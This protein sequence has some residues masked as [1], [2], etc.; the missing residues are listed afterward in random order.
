MLNNAEIDFDNK[1]EMSRLRYA[2]LDMT[3]LYAEAEHM[4]TP[5]PLQWRG[6]NAIELLSLSFRR[7]VAAHEPQAK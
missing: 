3:L 5:T 1:V 7:R 4:P 2:P 6:H